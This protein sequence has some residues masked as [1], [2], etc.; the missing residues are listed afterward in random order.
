VKAGTYADIAGADV[1]IVAAGAAQ[2]SGET[3]L[4]LLERNIEVFRAIIPPVLQATP[5]AILL[6]AT[7]PVD[8]MTY[9]ARPISGLPAGRFIGSGTIL[10]TARLEAWTPTT[11][12]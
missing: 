1:V 2:K 9:A 7:N 6:I 5:D 8:I 4:A 11:R 3:R 10:D 12:R